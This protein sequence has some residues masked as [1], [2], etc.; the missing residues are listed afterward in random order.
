MILYGAQRTYELPSLQPLLG[1]GNTSW[2]KELKGLLNSRVII[3]R[4]GT[5]ALQPEGGFRLLF[6]L[7]LRQVRV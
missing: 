7:S 2:E 5:L 3:T 6:L 4:K 1:Q